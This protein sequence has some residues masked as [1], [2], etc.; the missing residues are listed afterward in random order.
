MGK[1]RGGTPGGGDIDMEAI[2]SSSALVSSHI[3]ESSE[4]SSGG[5]AAVDAGLTSLMSSGVTSRS[6]SRSLPLWDGGN[7]GKDLS[8][9]EG[10][11]SCR[12]CCLE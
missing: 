12:R 7:A 4:E 2:S 5:P 9:G 10:W 3:E 1:G 6:N 11:D 8:V